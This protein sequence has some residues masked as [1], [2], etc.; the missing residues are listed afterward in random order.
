MIKLIVTD[1]DGTLLTS[2][3]QLPP[4]FDA[5]MHRLQEKGIA[6]AAATGRN[7]VGIQ[8][9]FADKIQNM[10]FICDNGA[11]I[12]EHDQLM[13][14]ITIDK[15]LCHRVFRAVKE[16]GAVDVLAC[17]RKGTYYTVCSDEMQQRMDTYYAP[18]TFVEDMCAIDD[19]LFKISF[20]D[21]NGGPMV[22]GSYAYM[23]EMFGDELSIH[24]S[25]GIWADSMHK[26]VNKGEGVRALQE[27][28]GVTPEETLVFGDY[29]ND[30]PMFAQA[31]TVF[32]VADAPEE[33]KAYA[34]RVIKSGDEFG[35]TEAICEFVL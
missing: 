7:F 29:Y 33:V 34:S 8:S 15:S 17:G 1:L 18:V 35:V 16:Y 11:F 12:M 31:K 19:E 21:F 24:A 5:V 9:F 6:F 25:G 14:C 4:D 32:V 30:L 10:Y 28:L 20:A 27:M 26:S 22:S 3:K 2:D 13:R 23:K